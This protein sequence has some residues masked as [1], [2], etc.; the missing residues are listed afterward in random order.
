MSGLAERLIAENL[1]TKSP[2]LDLGNCGLD[3]TEDELY[4]PLADAKHL[5]SIDFSQKNSDLVFPFLLNNLENIF[6][7]IPCFL[8]KNLEKLVL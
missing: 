7:E 8:P 3:G 6:V 5:K 4:K 1:K 2:Y